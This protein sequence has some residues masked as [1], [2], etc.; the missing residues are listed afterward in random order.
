MDLTTYAGLRAAIAEEIN[1]DDLTATIPSWI[2]MAE[3]GFNQTLRLR[4][5]I[6]R[7]HSVFTGPYSVLPTDFLQ[8]KSVSTAIRNRT[9]KLVYASEEVMDD[10]SGAFCSDRP[11]HF[12]II[13]NEMKI[14]PVKAEAEW[15]VSMTYY[16]TIPS[17]MD[18]PTDTSWLLKRSPQL[19]L[20]AALMHSAPYLIEDERLPV[21]GQLAQAAAAS[22]AT[23]DQASTQTGSTLIERFRPIG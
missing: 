10:L 18:S 7:E 1:R 21:W 12:A 16:A 4:Q 9:Q 20:Y 3:S 14:G 5:M 23:E 13:G 8:M 6:R 17:I 19:Y 2:Q 15:D 11:S 22:L